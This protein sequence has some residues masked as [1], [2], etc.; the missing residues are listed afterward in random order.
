MLSL[1]WAIV[2]LLWYHQQ[3]MPVKMRNIKYVPNQKIVIN[4]SPH[5][6]ATFPSWIFILVLL[7]HPDPTG[8]HTH[9]QTFLHSTMRTCFS[10]GD[11]DMTCIIAHITGGLGIVLTSSPEKGAAGITG[12]SSIVFVSICHFPTN[13]ASY[14]FH[15]LLIFISELLK[16]R[17]HQSW[18]TTNSQLWRQ[19]ELRKN[20]WFLKNHRFRI[21]TAICE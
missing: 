10:I 6:L 20:E 16:I 21:R 12:P 17:K 19:N 5:P 15:D 8:L 1:L 13:L 9:G 18:S 11:G 3:I 14:F 2:T 4:L 7:G